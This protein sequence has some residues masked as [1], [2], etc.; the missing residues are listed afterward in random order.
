MISALSSHRNV[1]GPAGIHPIDI[2]VRITFVL[3][4]MLSAI[5]TLTTYLFTSS[6]L[7]VRNFFVF[8]FVEEDFC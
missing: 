5:P 4:V 6:D 3:L 1:C 2:Q 7:R 8:S